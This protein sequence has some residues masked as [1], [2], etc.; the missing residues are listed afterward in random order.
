MVFNAAQSYPS[1]CLLHE[2]AFVVHAL[3]WLGT[4][5]GQSLGILLDL[6]HQWV[7]HHSHGLIGQISETRCRRLRETK[8]QHLLGRRSCCAL[9]RCHLI[10]RA[11]VR[12]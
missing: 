1:V 2:C 4:S 6:D 9:V 8:S 12:Q 5:A 7:I 10:A 11:A 3:Q